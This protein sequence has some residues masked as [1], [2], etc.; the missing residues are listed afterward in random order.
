MR[1]ADIVLI[2]LA[3]L[4]VWATLAGALGGDRWTDE[5]TVRFAT[6]QSQLAAA[7]PTE[8]PGGGVLLNWTMPV[9]ATS[10]SFVVDLAFS[11]QAIR[12]GGAIV[13]LRVTSPD[14]QGHPPLTQSWTIPQ[15][16][17]SGSLQLN[18]TVSWMETPRTLRDTTSSAHGVHW[19]APLIL[20]VVVEPP[21][22]LPLASYSFTAT[23]T[24]T[25]ASYAAL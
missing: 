24:G 12:G 3:V 25:V 7:G 1:K 6:A 9:N 23:A 13:T 11:G 4:A 17:T 22:D 10:A 20:Q 2:V 21:S 14:G 16:S 15:G 19:M 18:T 5:R 8:V